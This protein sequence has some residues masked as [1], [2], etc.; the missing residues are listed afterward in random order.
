M[1]PS[2]TNKKLKQIYQHVNML[3]ARSVSYAA[4]DNKDIETDL[5]FVQATT[6]DAQSIRMLIKELV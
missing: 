5:K 2:E 4:K 3:Q 1:T 6:G